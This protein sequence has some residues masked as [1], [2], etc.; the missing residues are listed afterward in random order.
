MDR[1]LLLQ[2][3]GLF[4]VVQLLGLYVGSTLIAD[5]VQATLITD[6]PDDVVN[7]VGLF[8]YILVFT[9]IMLVIIKFLKDK[10][11]YYFLKAIEALAIFATSVIVLA[12]FADFVMW[13]FGFNAALAF[14]LGTA[15]LL[16]VL[17]IVLAKNVLL[18]NITSVIAT[19]GA[20]ALLGVSLG[21][22]P[23][24]VLL[25]LLAAYD[26]IAVFKTKHMVTM[27]KAITKKNLSFTFA[28]PTSKHTFELGTGDMVMPL[29]MGVSVLNEY[30]SAFAF[31]FN[32]VPAFGVLAAALFGLLWTMNISS[33]NIGTALPALPPQ[34]VCMLIVLVA[35]KIFLL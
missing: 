11:L 5:D 22:I 20:G 4:I 29:M 9:A 8:L 17:R 14:V 3:V 23:V 27:A 12:A 28:M 35:I 21:V 19:V 24:L 32:L 1:K 33:K 6:N 2:L 10:F 25:L 18:R 26:F 30:N 34:T 16:V 7:S 13:F 31:P 15:I